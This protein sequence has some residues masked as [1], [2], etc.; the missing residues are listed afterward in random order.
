VNSYIRIRL[1]QVPAAWEDI[2]TTHCFEHGATGVTEA[3]HFAQPDLTYDPKIL[4]DKAHDMDVYFLEKPSQEYFDKILEY[5][6]QLKWDIFEEENKD[7]LAE[8]KKNFKPFKLVGPYWVVPSWMEPPP[9]AEKPLFI[10]PGMAF[11]TGTH[12]TTRMASYFVH[13]MCQ[14]QKKA[15]RDLATT[16]LVDVGT[17]TGILAMI[18]AGEGVGKIRG[19]EIDPDARRVARE[20][21]ERNHLARVEIPESQ[22]EEEKTQYDFVI[23]NIIDG[24]LIQIKTELLKILKPQGE[25]F[26]TGILTERD[27]GFFEKFVEGSGLKVVRRLEDEEWVGYWLKAP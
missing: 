11:G 27:A 13:K 9:E 23:A 7:W 12:A 4:Y 15:G 25:I 3:L 1:R 14:N 21:L 6:P 2:L 26:L 10:D 24:V 17:G 8:W 16:T 19:L 22:L 20:N 5:V 18:A